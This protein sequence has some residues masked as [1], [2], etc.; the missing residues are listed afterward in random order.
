MP[1]IALRS[2]RWIWKG[3]RQKALQGAARIVG[4]TDR[5]RIAI[6]GYHYA[7]DL[8]NI[9]ETLDSLAP[10]YRLRLRHHS[11]YYYDSILYAEPE[12]E[13]SIRD[14]PESTTGR[15]SLEHP[16]PQPVT[17]PLLVPELPALQDLGSL[18]PPY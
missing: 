18:H 15:S 17:V 13:M 16:A 9:V 11:N 10:D 5:P 1:W 14:A 2:S 12:E 6:T 7:E 3:L 8:L 4:T